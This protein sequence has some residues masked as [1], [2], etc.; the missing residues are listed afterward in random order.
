[1]GYVISIDVGGTHTDIVCS[2]GHGVKALKVPSIPGRD[3][4]AVFNGLALAAQTN[5]VSVEELLGNCERLI[6]ASTIATNMFLQHKIHKAGLLATKG[7]RDAIYF[8]DL[9]KFD[10][11]NL[12]V[13]PPWEIVPRY[14]R[15]GIEERVNYR[16]EVLTPLNESDVRD[17]ARIFGEEKVEAVAICFLWSFLNPVHEQ[18]AREIIKEELPG[19]PVVISYDVLP[20]MKEWERTFCTA[21]SAAVIPG[22]ELHLTEFR[23][24]CIKTGLKREPFI[25]QASGGVATVGAILR[26]PL[27]S[28][29]SGPAGGAAAGVFYG[30]RSGAKDVL[31]IDMGGTS[32]DVCFLEDCKIPITKTKRIE[33]QPFAIPCVDIHTIGAGG[34]S[35]A[36]MDTGGALQVGPQSAGAV[37]GPACY[38]MGGQEPT[39]T[40]AFLLL[41]YLD[42]NFFL[43]GRVGLQPELAE[44]AFN[45]KI[46]KRS[47]INLYEIAWSVIDLVNHRMAN[48]MRV[49]SLWRGIDV[50]SCTLVVG[51]GAGPLVAGKL[52]EEIGIKRIFVPRESG[53]LCALGVLTSHLKHEAV[54]AYAFDSDTADPNEL[55]KLY[56]DLERENEELLLAEGATQEKIRHERLIDTRYVGQLYELETPVPRLRKYKPKDISQIAN[57]FEEMHDRL[58]HYKL[59]GALIQFLSCRVESVGEVEKIKLKEMSF[60]GDN[61]DP[62]LKS[63]RRIYSPEKAGFVEAPVYDCAKL[64]YGNVLDGLAVVESEG[65]TLIVWENQRLTVDSYGDFILDVLLHS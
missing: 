37:P 27:N 28:I 46:A 21:L 43:G 29:L 52:A 49:V 2:D 63:K 42:P 12:H 18:R 64:G 55:T 4:E 39:V 3:T 54:G 32:F 60:V 40:D 59:P 25:A 20:M 48:A 47:G 10:V 61:A 22:L 11:W 26:K 38:G 62:A 7:H 17:A 19:I 41:G 1:M 5:G 33:E 44:K 50:A 13:P 51:G 23:E 65:S 58:Y 34:G 36:W 15:L 24:E 8:G 16:G 45:D 57:L 35:I 6:Y 9:Y 53:G 14:L 31:T 56:E 30:E